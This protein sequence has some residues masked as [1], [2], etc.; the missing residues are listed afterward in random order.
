MRWI[1]GSFLLLLF[2]CQTTPKG[3]KV[4]VAANL[5]LP[6]EEIAAQ[7]E[8]SHNEKV[9][10]IPGASG[11]L[12]TQIENGAPY[13]LFISANERFAKHLAQKERLQ[14]EPVR[15]IQGKLLL[16]HKA[17]LNKLGPENELT[18]GIKVAIADPELAPYGAAAKQYLQEQQIW[19]SIQSNLVIGKSVGQ[20]NQYLVA[21]VVDYAFTAPAARSVDSLLLAGHW[22][23]LAV[24]IP[25]NHPFM[26]LKEA[27]PEAS[28]FLAYL[29]GEDAIAIFLKHGYSL[30]R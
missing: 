26:L 30:N 27:G 13:D 10:L 21:G 19:E 5:L 2:A 6:L 23:E 11:S 18:E 7:Y 24:D 22:E 28:R 9:L 1:F 25:L 16:W 3:L 20:V 17:T 8:Q 29:E 4:A 12:A 14:A 15:L